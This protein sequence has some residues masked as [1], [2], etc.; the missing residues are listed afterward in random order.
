ML[1]EVGFRKSDSQ[2]ARVPKQTCAAVAFSDTSVEIAKF[3]WFPFALAAILISPPV[4]KFELL[5][6]SPLLLEP[7]L[8]EPGVSK[9][10]LEDPGLVSSLD[11]PAF[12]EL[13]LPE[14]SSEHGK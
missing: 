2:E 5:K 6:L 10:S 7:S 3:N 8:D 1:G 4:A 12:P 9:S 13:E 11:E 14:P